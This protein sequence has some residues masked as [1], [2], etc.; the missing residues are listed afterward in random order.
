LNGAPEKP[1]NLH[2]NAASCYRTNQSF[3]AET[4]LRVRRAGRFFAA[5]LLTS[6][7]AIGHMPRAAAH[8][9]VVSWFDTSAI[10]EVEGELTELRWQN[11]HVI[12]TLLVE[13]ADGATSSWQI[14]TL[15]ISGIS[16]WGMTQDLFKL[17][18]HLRVAGNPSRR[19]MN[20]HR[21]FVRNILLPEGREL[22]L[23]GTPRW[24][25]TTLVGSEVLPQREG[26]P[27]RPDLGL[28]RTWSTGVSGGFLFPE[29]TI[30]PGFDLKRQYPLTA[31]ASAALDAFDLTV[32]D[33]TK[34]CR[35][36]G[37]PAIMEQPYPMEFV[38]R[39]SSILIRL[40][41]YDTQRIV[42]MDGAAAPATRGLLGHSVGRWEGGTLVVTTTNSSWGYYDT[43][44]LP[45]S[46][47]AVMVERFTPSADGAH[48]D[49]S[50][51]VTDAATFTRP[52]ELTKFWIWRPEIVVEKFEC[53]QTAR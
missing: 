50:L 41:E 36:K 52:V 10:I 46:A 11:P 16:R 31:A 21:L 6:W 43:I 39:G 20:S 42:H 37:M 28:F 9:S 27:S 12:L 53:V 25:Q 34:D 22:V 44:G 23:I 45:L 33:P 17:G 26:D 7:A 38:D 2:R 8:H 40:E 32:D 19:S 48:L 14:E 51:T 18:A 29:T 13:T 35:S 49:Y 24:S 5:C 4:R 47:D 3:Q 1:M 15:S 30:A